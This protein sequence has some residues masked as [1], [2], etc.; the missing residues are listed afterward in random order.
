MRLKNDVERKLIL[1][2]NRF[3]IFELEY[4]LTILIILS[5]IGKKIFI[6]F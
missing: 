6:S 5:I 3:V 2:S 4:K 1:D